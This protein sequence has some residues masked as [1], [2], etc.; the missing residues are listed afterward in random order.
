MCLHKPGENRLGELMKAGAP[1]RTNGETMAGPS[2]RS[3]P[4]PAGWGA[5]GLRLVDVERCPTEGR[6]E[7]GFSWAA[8]GREWESGSWGW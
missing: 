3:Q 7:G 2:P 1:L 8:S 6:V 4:L 5:A